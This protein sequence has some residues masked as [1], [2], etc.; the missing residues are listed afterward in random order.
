MAKIYDI[1]DFDLNTLILKPKNE[2]LIYFYPSPILLKTQ[3]LYCKILKKKTKYSMYE[4]IISNFNSKTDFFSLLD[5][6]IVEMAKSNKIKLPFDQNE[7]IKYKSLIGPDGNISFKIINSKDFN[8]IIFDK[9]N[10]I[11]HGSYLQNEIYA[12]LVFEL[13]GIWCN[14]N[15]FGIYLRLHQ[16]K[17]KHENSEIDYIL[18]DSSS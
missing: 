16:V 14:D 4:I 18:S 7:K 13:V 2:H 5:K 17:E 3:N 9:K 15:I 11:I 8:T 6:M 1:N 12:Y 10:I